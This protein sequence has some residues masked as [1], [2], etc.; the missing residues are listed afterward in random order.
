M[1]EAELQ[2]LVIAAARLGGWR[3]YHTADSRR[4]NPGWPDLVLVRGRE[5]L[6]VEL[7]SEKGR[8]RPEQREWLQA[9]ERV[10]TFSTG[11]LRPSDADAFIT[12]R[13]LAR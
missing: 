7:K 2:E 4:S 8:V 10:E 5:A 13:L 12:D 6:F 11:I 3:W 1:S 9:L